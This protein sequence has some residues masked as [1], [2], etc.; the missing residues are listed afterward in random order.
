MRGIYVNL[1]AHSQAAGSSL[2]RFQQAL[3]S[4]SVLLRPVS[5]TTL[6][7]CACTLAACCC[8][9]LA[10][11]SHM[12]RTRYSG[13]YKP[14]EALWPPPAHSF[15]LPVLDFTVWLPTFAG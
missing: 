11:L 13:Q 10:K 6:A 12:A 8:M 7:A 14:Q 2:C 3:G 9:L 1:A 15:I 5:R 4:T